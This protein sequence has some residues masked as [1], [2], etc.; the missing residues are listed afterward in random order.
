MFDRIFNQPRENKEKQSSL[1]VAAR[2]GAQGLTFLSCNVNIGANRILG[3]FI[4]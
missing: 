3:S 4:V 1:Q 2:R